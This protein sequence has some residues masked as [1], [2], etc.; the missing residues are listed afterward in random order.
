MDAKLQ[1]WMDR[2][3]RLV[4]ETR[5][6]RQRIADLEWL[7]AAVA[8]HPGVPAELREAAEQAFKS[9]GRCP[10]CDVLEVVKVDVEFTE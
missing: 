6:Q 8:K 5:Q 3:I 2:C 9:V 7:A 4:E 10:W 1:R